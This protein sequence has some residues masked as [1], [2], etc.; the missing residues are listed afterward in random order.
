M[1]IQRLSDRL[2]GVAMLILAFAYGYSAQQFEEPFG[3]AE[4]IGPAA[5][6]TI[7]SM[8]LAIAALILLIKPQLGQKW[9]TGYLWINLIVIILALIIFAV[10]LE[11]LGFVISATLFASFVSWRMGAKLRAAFFISLLY[12]VGLFVLFNYGLGL[13]LPLGWLGGLR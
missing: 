1:Q 6:P 11:T 12:N 2:L 9:P 13:A 7:L 3:M 10:C 5:F 8:I 4:T